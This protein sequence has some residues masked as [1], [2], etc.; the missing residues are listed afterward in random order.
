LLQTAAIPVP[1]A[2]RDGREQNQKSRKEPSSAPDAKMVVFAHTNLDAVKS[3]STLQRE[4][5]P[6]SFF[7]RLGFK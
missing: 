3:A 7:S 5:S 2:N 1:A 4:Y 6:Q